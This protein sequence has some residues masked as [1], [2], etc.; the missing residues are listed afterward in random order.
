M[1]KPLKPLRPYKYSAETA[2]N[3][4]Y[5]DKG[6]MKGPSILNMLDFRYQTLC[7]WN[8]LTHTSSHRCIVSQG[9]CGP[10][11]A[12]TGGSACQCIMV[13]LELDSAEFPT[14]RENYL[15]ILP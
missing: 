6:L 13:I 4:L 3:R 15:R 2:E 5:G 12:H 9:A 11:S 10:M 7:S 14:L 8:A 1:L